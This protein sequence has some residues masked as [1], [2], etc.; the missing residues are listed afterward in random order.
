M[1]GLEFRKPDFCLKYAKNNTISHSIRSLRFLSSLKN[2]APSKQQASVFSSY[3][4]AA[5]HPTLSQAKDRVAKHKMVSW[6]G[7]G[8]QVLRTI[9]LEQN[10]PVK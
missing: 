3:G 7:E 2:P 1:A 6:K 9:Y 8:A 10:G 5:R 4:S